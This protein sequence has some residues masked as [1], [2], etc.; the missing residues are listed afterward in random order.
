[1]SIKTPF[2]PD[3]EA[4]ERA[5]SFIF[6]P[7]L[8]AEIHDIVLTLLRE[9]VE[10]FESCQGGKGH[11]MAEPT[12]RFEGDASE[13][14]RALSVALA[15][16]LPVRSLNRTWAMRDNLIHGP[17]WEM[18]FFPPRGSQQEADRDTSMRY[19]EQMVAREESRTTIVTGDV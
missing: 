8:D 11:C 7:P 14:L 15:H 2:R 3:P 1:M 18:K 12:V 10:T 4:I 19:A 17:W 5:R 13:G 9:G 16:G 6:E